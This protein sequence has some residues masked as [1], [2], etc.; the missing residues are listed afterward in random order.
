M[1]CLPLPLTQSVVLQAWEKAEAKIPTV[2]IVNYASR[3]FLCTS[4]VFLS[5]YS[6]STQEYII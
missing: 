4:Q 3:D 6:P 2:D 1:G 5:F